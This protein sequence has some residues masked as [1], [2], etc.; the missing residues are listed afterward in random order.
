LPHIMQGNE[1]W[2]EDLKAISS[3]SVFIILSPSCIH[4]KNREPDMKF[5]PS[6][7]ESKR[8]L[9]DEYENWQLMI[10]DTNLFNRCFLPKPMVFFG[11][12]M[13]IDLRST[14]IFLSIFF[15]L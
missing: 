5:E 10:T 11:S 7:L 9:K 8:N 14:N 12:S 15:K 2:K 6:S 4:G 3:S 13:N 1:P